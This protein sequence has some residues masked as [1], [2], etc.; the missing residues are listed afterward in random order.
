MHSLVSGRLPRFCLGPCVISSGAR[1]PQGRC[2]RG[3]RQICRRS[4]VSL[5]ALM[6]WRL[7]TNW[8]GGSACPSFIV[9]S[10]DVCIPAL[11]IEAVDLSPPPS[12]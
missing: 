11:K 3:H 10:W 12:L 9:K 6:Y 4:W 7:G 2:T 8:W 5:T 1:W